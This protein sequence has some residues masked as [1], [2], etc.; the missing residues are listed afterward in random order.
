[1]AQYIKLFDKTYPWTEDK[2]RQAYPSTSFPTPFPVPEGFALVFEAPKPDY[3]SIVQTVVE[4][5][6]ELTAL[7]KYQQKWNVVQ[8]YKEYTDEQ[9]VV[10]TVAEQEAQAREQ[11]RKSKVPQKVFM[12][13][14]RLALLAAGKLAQ[15]NSAIAAL[16]EPL[17]SQVDIEWNYASEVERTWPSLVQLTQSLG[18]TDLELDN[19][20]IEAAKL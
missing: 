16:P 17:K 20:F 11:D 15:V 14:A 1:M 7:G 19:L 2:I 5:T 13:Q 12:R 3:D 4:A 8:L 9:G 6:P 18:M 10:H